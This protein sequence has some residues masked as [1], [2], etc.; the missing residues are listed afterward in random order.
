MSGIMQRIVG[1]TRSRY[2]KPEIV[3][4]YAGTRERLESAMI[5]L[6][7]T[8]NLVSS[9]KTHTK[10][11]IVNKMVI[12]DAYALREELLGEL[13]S[14]PE[15]A[16]NKD[17]LSL[18]ETAKKFRT[19]AEKSASVKS[20]RFDQLTETLGELESRRQELKLALGKLDLAQEMVTSRNR[21]AE[22]S[23]KAGVGE[24]PFQTDFRN[25]LR[26]ASALAKEAEA[27]AELKGFV[28]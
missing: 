22:I 27:L 7:T 11:A 15:G 28:E 1:I 6:T 8:I 16:H 10:K 25:E 13:V 19:I 14:D 18:Y 26:A 9:Q 5:A 12:G 20:E 17:I 23:S 21:L 3:D 2:G 24:L 4:N